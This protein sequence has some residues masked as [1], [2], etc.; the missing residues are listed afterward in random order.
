MKKQFRRVMFILQQDE[1]GMLTKRLRESVSSLEEIV[2]GNMELEPARCRRSQ[3]TWYRLL[4]DLSGSVYQALQSSMT[5]CVCPG[6]HDFGLRLLSQ[7]SILTPHDDEEEVVKSQK[8][9]LILSFTSTLAHDAWATS[10]LW[11]LLSL[12]VG[13]SKCA[14]ATGARVQFALPTPQPTEIPGTGG[15]NGFGDTTQTSQRGSQPISNLCHAV[16]K[17]R[18]QA[19]KESCGRISDGLPKGRI[20]DVYPL[21]S[22]NDSDDWSP[23]SLGAALSE[24]AA[25]AGLTCVERLRL[26]WIITA[27]VLQLEETP[28][29]PGT[30]SKDEIFLAR[31]NG[32]L[33]SE[34]VFVMKRLPERSSAAM[35]VSVSSRNSTSSPCEIAMFNATSPRKAETIKALGILLVELIFGQT[36]DRLQAMLGSH[37]AVMFAPMDPPSHYET[38][39]C[40]IDQINTRV[41]AN[42]CS[43]VK[44]CMSGVGFGDV[45]GNDVLIGVLSLLEQ[46]LRHVMG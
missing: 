19:A 14:T 25:L 6:F 1:Y 30:L 31:H 34:D 36:I 11:N 10:K 9:N 37:N 33:L 13:T 46:D 43:A 15:M 3:M 23:V 32:A 20:Y 38:V 5:K 26:A 45:A 22:P 42:Y 35:F 21:G 18:K 39:L 4:R 40:L 41:G 29:L 28:W 12:S 27:G 7:P 17:S 24:D 2:S 8:F 16:R 44:R